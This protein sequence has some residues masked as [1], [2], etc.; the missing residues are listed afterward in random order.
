METTCEVPESPWDIYLR[1][2]PCRDVLDLLANKWTA[3]VLGALS[4]RPHRFGELRRAVGGIS[5][6]M[7]TQNLRAFERDGLVT[8]TV[9]PTTPPTVEYALTERGAGAG[10]LLMA[11]SEWSVANF[12]GILESRKEYDSRVME[13]VG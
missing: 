4:R 10:A 1:N 12:D 8:R 11:V 9:F 13:P 7:L 2:C 3:L 5:Q 6:K